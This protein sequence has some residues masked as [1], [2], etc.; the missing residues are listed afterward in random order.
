MTSVSNSGVDVGLDVHDTISVSVLGVVTDPASRSD[1][2]E[3]AG[4]QL[5]QAISELREL[6]PACTRTSWPGVDCRGPS[7]IWSA[8]P[9][10]S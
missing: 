4:D 8:V 3:Q 7:P 1:L 2:I 9:E 10:S 5:H 6:A